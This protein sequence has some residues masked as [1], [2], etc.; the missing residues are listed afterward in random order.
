MSPA[1]ARTS[2]VDIINAARHLIC[3]KGADAVTLNDVAG[4]VGI[5]APS[6]YKRF[7]NRQDLMRRI[8]DDFLADLQQD[9][10]GAVG[11][12]SASETARAMAYAWRARALCDPELFRLTQKVD[13][14]TAAMEA[15]RAATAPALAVMEDLVGSHDAL[16]AARCFT[17]F[18][19]GFITME[20]D[21]NFGLGGSVEEAFSFSVSTLIEGLP[22]KG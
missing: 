20:I 2:D 5:R 15:E 14:K 16:N 4:A 12:R 21:G 17:A 19:M 18:L 3:S 7:A 9:L 10:E 13:L 22:N 11:T 6:L 1:V 8:K